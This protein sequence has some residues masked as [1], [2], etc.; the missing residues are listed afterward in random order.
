MPMPTAEA[1][2]LR[3]LPRSFGWNGERKVSAPRHLWFRQCAYPRTEVFDAIL[4]IIAAFPS[5]NR[6][7]TPNEM[8]QF[9]R[10]LNAHQIR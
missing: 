1:A 6:K 8:I 5:I 9:L 3:A 2:Y 7:F 4:S 10:K